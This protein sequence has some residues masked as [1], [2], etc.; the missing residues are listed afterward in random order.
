MKFVKE[1][2]K[3]EKKI[4]FFRNATF[5]NSFQLI[6]EISNIKYHCW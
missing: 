2:L 4:F 6:V 1:N 3:K 5:L